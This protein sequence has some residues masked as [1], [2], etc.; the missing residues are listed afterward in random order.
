MALFSEMMDEAGELRNRIV[1]LRASLIYIRD[2][3]R[4]R[5]DGAEE[6]RGRDTWISELIRVCD[7]VLMTEM[8]PAERK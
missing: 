5:I 1:K 6:S 4:E 8:H 2:E 7:S 3:L